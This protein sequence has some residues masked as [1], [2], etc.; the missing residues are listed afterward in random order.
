MAKRAVKN[1]VRWGVIS[2]ARIGWE[3]VLPGMM[4]SKEIEIRAIASRKLPTAKKW[5]KKL[6]I[7][8]AYGSYEALLDDPEIEAVY[9]PLPNHLHVPLTLAAAAKGKHVLCEKPIALTAEE[10]ENFALA[11]LGQAENAYGVE[12]AITQMRVLDAIFR[13]EKSGGWE[14]V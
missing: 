6:G 14:Q 13:S 12:D 1:P 8:V 3:K 2:T 11:V 7:P 5:A 10:A 9:N 4:K